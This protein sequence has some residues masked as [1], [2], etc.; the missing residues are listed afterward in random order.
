MAVNFAQAPSYNP[1]SNPSFQD[2]STL[3]QV[4]STIAADSCPRFFNFHMHT[5]YSDGQLPPE[6]L[7]EQAISIGL[8]GFAITDHHTI[9]G[10]QA[11]HAWL[12]QWQQAHQPTIPIPH[13][14]SGVE[15]NANLLGV[16]V[17]ILGYAFNADHLC[18]Q[19]YLQRATATGSDYQAENVISALHEAGGLAVL[20]HPARYRRSPAELIPEAA[21][22]GID[23]VETYYAYTNPT[24]W[25][26]SPVQTK[27]VQ[28]LSATYGL[29][30]SCGTDTHG[31]SLLQRL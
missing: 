10:F 20:A 23:G 7:M 3:K 26:P 8:K 9:K 25:Q 22:L 30:N 29:L 28:E 16:E 4:F 1:S 11:A 19:P 15:I 31:L 21:N 5:V 12:E 2:V 13:L 24:P 18:L 14:W 27:Q 6:T 17:H